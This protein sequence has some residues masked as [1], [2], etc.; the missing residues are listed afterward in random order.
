MA[1]IK[2]KYVTIEYDGSVEFEE[3]EQ[4]IGRVAV[5][6]ECVEMIKLFEMSFRSLSKKLP[7]DV[8]YERAL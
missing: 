3:F 5:Y 8:S 7:C 2:G 6:D 1:K 4:V